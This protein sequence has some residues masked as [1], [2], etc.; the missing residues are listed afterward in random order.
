[1]SSVNP[2]VSVWL[3]PVAVA[4]LLSIPLAVYSSRA[5]IGR[6]FRRW[7]VFLIPEELAPPQVIKDLQAGVSRRQRQKWEPEGF[8]RAAI[9]PD[10]NAVHVGLLRGKAPRS[11]Q[12][13][14]RNKSLQEKALQEGLASLT[15]SE[16]AYLLQDAK[17]MA[18]LHRHVCQIHDSNF[19]IQWGLTESH[20]RFPSL[21]ADARQE[22]E[23]RDQTNGGANRSADSE[24]HRQTV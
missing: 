15:R 11:P 6:A 23:M 14:A 1:M 10:A 17:S 22:S 13:R 20:R 4:L 9:D 16:R 8:V 18:A 2:A 5:A 7:G 12:A 21:A 3:L 24:A 19:A